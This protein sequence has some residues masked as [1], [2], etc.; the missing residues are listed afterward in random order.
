MLKKRK[1]LLII[2]GSIAALI[3]VVVLNLTRSS[4]KTVSVKV[5]EV[6]RGYLVSEVSASGKVQPRTEV[7]ISANVSGEIIA[8][9]IVEG[10]AVA[11]GVLL[12][13][14]DPRN[15]EAALRQAEAGLEAGV[16]TLRLE[17]AQAAEAKLVCERQLALHERGL[18][19]QET[20]DAARTRYETTQAAAEAARS[21]MQQA[22]AT[23]DQARENLG[24][25]TIRCPIDG[26]VTDLRS[27]VGEIVMGSQTYQASIIMVVSD[28]SEIE[29]EIEVDET[30]IG[31]VDLQQ[32]VKIS[33][34]AFPDTEFVGAVN[35]V[36]NSAQISG[37]G[38]QDQV[39]NFLV[40]VLIIDSVPNIKPGMTATCRITTDR[41]ESA[42]T[43]PIGAVVLRDESKLKRAGDS[44]RTESAAPVGEAVAADTEDDGSGGDKPDTDKKPLQGVF[45][46]RDNKAIFTEVETGIADQQ[47]IEVTLGLSEG[48][49]IVVGSFRTLRTLEDGDK[50][51]PEK[52][53]KSD[54]DA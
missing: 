6:K 48:D 39:T 18:T 50:V 19:S 46:I 17:E 34:D 36:G 24:Y 21:R 44:V 40:T 54:E 11:K 43:V 26:Y 53:G 13:Q 8:I 5:G 51:E 42:L 2:G 25:T 45:V 49:T 28:L 30:D 29:V 16:A 23:V 35:Q 20:F 15:Y 9:P 38:T 4:E 22:R 32:P 27:E 14:I 10:Q 37:A 52:K 1:K 47:N 33:L 41:R 3:I 12:V 31:N 7:N